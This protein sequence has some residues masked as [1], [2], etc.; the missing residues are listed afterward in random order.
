VPVA[1]ALAALG[2]Y[3]FD[4]GPQVDVWIWWAATVASWLV[5]LGVLIGPDRRRVHDLLARTYVVRRAGRHVAL[6]NAQVTA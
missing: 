2:L 6:T 4:L 3:E 5:Y 1:P